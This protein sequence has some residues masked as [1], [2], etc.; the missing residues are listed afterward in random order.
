MADGSWREYLAVAAALPETML[1]AA[2]GSEDEDEEEEQFRIHFFVHDECQIPSC[3]P[4]CGHAGVAGGSRRGLGRRRGHRDEGRRR[5]RRHHQWQNGCG[6][7]R[8][9]KDT[10]RPQ[11]E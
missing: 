6:Q 10:E 11:L 8:E 3:L 2:G 5:H 1:T 9:L 7:P 4:C